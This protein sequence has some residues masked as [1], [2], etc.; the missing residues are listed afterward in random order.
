MSEELW[1]QIIAAL[2]GAVLTI[3]WRLIDRYLP[4]DTGQHPLPDRPTMT[5]TDAT[6]TEAEG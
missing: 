4:D 1:A 5:T 2:A 3:L 6:T